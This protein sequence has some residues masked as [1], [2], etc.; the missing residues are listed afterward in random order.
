M[1]AETPETKSAP[2][3]RA[4]VVVP[5]V[6]AIQEQMFGTDDPRGMVARTT[7]T[8]GALGHVMKRKN[9]STIIQEWE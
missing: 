6:V 8:A 5:Q 9:R 7:D 2:E 1:T 3:E 4:V